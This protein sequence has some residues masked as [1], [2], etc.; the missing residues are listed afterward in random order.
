[1]SP[2]AVRQQETVMALYHPRAEFNHIWLRAHG[3]DEIAALVRL[4]GRFR[5]VGIFRIHNMST[6]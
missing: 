1:L 2:D 6:A 4:W 3:R 5:H